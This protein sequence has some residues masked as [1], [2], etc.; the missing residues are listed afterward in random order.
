MTRSLVLSLFLGITALV[1]GCGAEGPVDE[2][3]Q[4]LTVAGSDDGGAPVTAKSTR[5]PVVC[6]G[7]VCSPI[8]TCCHNRCF[9][10]REDRY[11]TDRGGATE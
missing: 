11:C 4:A 2:A 9:I 7:V 3:A 5:P 1:T 8:A 6:G 10:P